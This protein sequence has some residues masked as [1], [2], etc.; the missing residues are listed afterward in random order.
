MA[1]LEVK[2]LNKSF[3]ELHV[4]KGINFSVEQG[5]TVSVI[6][7]SGGGK[8]TLLRC[9]NFLEIPSYGCIS[10]NGEALFDSEEN[11]KQSD[12]DLRHNKIGR[13]HV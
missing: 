6:G 9:M 11:R 7:P 10:V 13:A 12:G 4:L 8:T 3:G 2:N 1:L 5:E